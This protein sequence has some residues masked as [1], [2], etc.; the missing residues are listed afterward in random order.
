MVS[1]A[2]RTTGQ[3]WRATS[4][5]VPKL[6]GRRE[7]IAALE[8]ELRQAQEGNFRVVLLLGEAGVGK[9]RLGRELL[10]RHA[11]VTGL[12]AQA[13]PL[14]ASAAFGLWTDA[15]DPFLQP[16]SDGEVLELCGGLLDDLAS[17]FHRVALVRGAVPDRDPPL[18]RLLQGLARLLTN[19]LRRTP[20]VVLLDDV[21]YADA[22]SWETLR[23]FARHLDDAP[24]LVI[25]TSRP[26]EL[27]THDVAVPVL[28]DLDQD[29]LLSRT[30][31]GPLGRSALSELT[32][33]V[34]ERPAPRALV[35]W[36][37]ERSQG[38]PLFAIGLLRALLQEGGDLSAPHLR[39]LP[40][41]LT[42]RVTSE[43][44]RFDAAPQ[45][46]LELLAVVGRPVPLSDLSAMM[47]TALE[48]VGAV[49]AELVEARI[50]VE[51]QR[52]G[53]VGYVLQH[54]LVRDVIYEATNGARRRVLHRQ[55][56]RCLLREGHLA[57]AALHFA[58]SADRG[59][60]EAVQVL[61]DAMR[62]AERREAYR[63]ALE[64]Q[65]ELV[66]L[67][68]SGDERWREVLEAMYARAEWLIDHRAETDAPVAVKALRAIDDLLDGS[69]D[70]ARRAIVNFRLA[71]FLA[72][73]MGE[74]EQANAACREA[75]EL[76]VRSGDQRQVLLAARELAWIKGLRGDL[77][78]M[79]ADARAV[80]QA[81]DAAGDRFVAMQGLSAI[82]YSAN[83]CGQLA[84]AE[85]VLRRAAAIARQ[86]D[87]D[88][89][90]TVVLGGLAAGLA[91]QGRVAETAALFEEAKSANPAYR[92]SI[93]VELEA[94]VGW[95]AGDFPGSLAAAHEVIAWLPKVNARRR[96]P[97]M[98]SGALSA[99]EAGDSLE[100]ERLLA[101]ARAILAGR[102]WSFHLPMTRW[103]ESVL[104]WHVRDA[105]E[106]VTLL[107]PAVAR[108]LEMQT[109]PLAA[110][111]LF[112]LAEAA[113][114][115][116][117]AA[118]AAH[119]EEHLRTVA[120]F[121]RLPVYWGLAAAGSAWA[122]LAAGDTEQAARSAQRA[123][124]LLSGTGWTGH[125]ARSH[126]LL[127][128]SLAA[129]A[130]VEAVA[131]LE[132]A[133]ALHERCGS[134]WRRDRSLEALRRLGAA[135]RRAVAVALGPAS[136]TRREHEVARLAATGMT[137]RE[138]AQA[139]FV[140]KRTVETHLAS[141]YAKLGVDSKLQL[142]RR[143]AELGLS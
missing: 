53:E 36:I 69:S 52:G 56:A 109:L 137:A 84:E 26:A 31:I 126:Y 27:A 98:V 28:F 66:E 44:R 141:I 90:L 60:S 40:E 68:P 121:I 79:G 23:Y 91:L 86:D 85:A 113:A 48:H 22:S 124:E 33:A 99:T 134:K 16:L 135:G 2:V 13:F 34:I 3:Q 47:G 35:D 72:W 37:A 111:P 67:L 75:H 62:Q 41:G 132:R 103:A 21:H 43:L 18:P 14:A 25:A 138:I 123:I 106:C 5:A 81:A 77:L 83:F 50:V 10:A 101:R 38:N 112:D 88:Y 17:L 94:L 102:D 92:D 122:R 59:D 54:P 96:V 29:T 74:L 20:L 93:L 95:I 115:A 71:N 39:R 49:L 51:V 30:E 24:L 100:A 9:S 82:S 127:G 63:E 139:L 118:A 32:E 61:L 143:A 125:V 57:E 116:G 140:G 64:L 42:E 70:H 78:G 46:L 6:A 131:A 80:V 11:E 120:E 142:V 128:R 65:A 15:L 133:A 58:R 4:R 136:L 110:L 19:I 87:K 105:S 130:R 1:G 76:F 7:E 108:V 45:G 119:A 104:A 97:G 55:A 73:G 8:D 114:D 117:D 12:V 107:V 129:S 89:R